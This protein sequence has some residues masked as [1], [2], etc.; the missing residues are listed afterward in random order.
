MK[1][2]TNKLS[3]N[4]WSAG[5]YAENTNEFESTGSLITTKKYSHIGENSLFCINNTDGTKYLGTN[6]G[7]QVT[8]GKTYTF[9]VRVYTPNDPCSILIVTNSWNTGVIYLSASDTIQTASVSCSA[10]SNDS[11]IYCRCNVSAGAFVYLDDLVLV[12]S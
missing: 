10:G 9:S 2:T 11:Y 4:Q 3:Y 8:S 7:I 1:D 6:P 12:E 5:E